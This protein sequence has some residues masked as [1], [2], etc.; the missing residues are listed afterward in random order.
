MFSFSR[1]M[2]VLFALN[3]S[4]RRLREKRSMR[5]S[6]MVAMNENSAKGESRQ[7]G[8]RRESKQAKEEKGKRAVT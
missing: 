8:K 1:S 5:F 7:R 4:A 3:A 6:F 2:D